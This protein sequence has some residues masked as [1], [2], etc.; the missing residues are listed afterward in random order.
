M[1]AQDT[2]FFDEDVTEEIKAL[3]EIN[4]GQVF[5]E[6]LTIDDCQMVDQDLAILLE[7]IAKQGHLRSITIANNQ[8]GQHSIAVLEDILK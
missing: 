6:T 4:I 5:I 8:F 7:V 1:I 2:D 3:R